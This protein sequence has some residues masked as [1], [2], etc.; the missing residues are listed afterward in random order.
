MAKSKVSDQAENI[1]NNIPIKDDERVEFLSSGPTMF[2]LAAS[3][4]GII[5]GIP[6]GRITN[7]VGDG[8]SGKTLHALEIAAWTFYNIQKITSNIFAPI[9]K[10]Y[11]VYNNVEDVMDFPIAK[12]FGEKFVASVEWIKTGTVEEFGR[13]YTRRVLALKEGEFLLYIIDSYDALTSEKSQERFIEAAEKDKEEKGSYGTEKAKYGSASFF[14]NICDI[15]SGKD[16]TLIIISQVRDN[17][18]AM[19]FGKKY[20]RAGGKALDF[21]THSVPW[22]AVV[23]K[24]KRTIKGEE[25]IYGVR[26]RAKFER[27]K[28][29]KPFR[30]AD[31]VILFDYGIDNISSMISFL[32]GPKV[33]KI[34]FDGAEFNRND[35]IKYIEDNELEDVLS[36]MCEKDWKAIETAIAPDRKPRF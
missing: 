25:R 29:A 22:L 14:S 21:Y 24:L 20:Y 28:V 26:V 8:S 9:K 16:A 33:D 13:D 2:N 27:N 6:R 10:I 31:T 34:S 36:D 12:M 23:E 15:S 32:Y 35:F 1:K 7:L 18:D 30:E 17:I 3:G 4:K 5:G 11:I 19:A